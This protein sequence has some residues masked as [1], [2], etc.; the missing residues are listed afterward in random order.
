MKDIMPQ[1]KKTKKVKTLKPQL[2]LTSTISSGAKPAKRKTNSVLTDLHPSPWDSESTTT[3]ELI[4]VSGDPLMENLMTALTKP[5]KFGSDH[6]K[7]PAEDAPEDTYIPPDDE[8]ELTKAQITEL[9]HCFPTSVTIKPK[10]ASL[11]AFPSLANQA[12]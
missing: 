4:E 3:N 10:I 9:A 11:N 5:F 7:T 6:D 2:T 1:E 8:A 12:Q